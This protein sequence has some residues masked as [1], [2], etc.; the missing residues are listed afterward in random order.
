ML[1]VVLWLIPVVILWALSREDEKRMSMIRH[2][3]RRAKRIADASRRAA[4]LRFLK[5]IK[6]SFRSEC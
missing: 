1:E 4:H 2:S 5:D 3:E 6:K